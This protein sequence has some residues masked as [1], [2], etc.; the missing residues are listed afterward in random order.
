MI[1][2]GKTTLPKYEDVEE[3][4]K[5]IFDTGMVSDHKYVKE[6]EEK[7]AELIGVK[8][9]VAGPSNTSAMIGCMSLVDK[10]EVIM[11]SFTIA[12]TYYAL[13]WNNLDPVL[14][15]CDEYCNIDVDEVKKNINEKTKAVLAVYM[16]G[17]ISK[18][19]EL[20]EICE[21]K[22]VDL[23][24]DAAQGFGGKWKGKYFGNFGKG[25]IFSF[26]PSKTM[27]IGE[28]AIVTTNDDKFAE[29]LRVVFKNG[30][31]VPGNMDSVRIGLNGRLP[32]MCAVIGI[33]ALKKINYY[34]ER[35]NK[36]A[37][38][39]KK[40]LKGIEGVKFLGAPENCLSTFKDLIITVDEGRDELKEELLKRDIHTRKYFYPPIHW[41]SSCKDEFKDLK[42]PKT[43]EMSLKVLSLPI[44]SHMPF[45]DVEEVCKNIREIKGEN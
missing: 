40:N 32:E 13:K 35:R 21:E 41:M 29:D 9:A 12:N 10:G 45:E 33:E 11:P 26:D 8:H 2:I 6:F 43:E 39:Y 18:M 42:L 30:M 23:F 14:V 38:L 25:E 44:Y 31:Q 19:D 1:P 28:G 5:E 37:E 7:A 4:F 17:S 34:I 36:L 24:I 22:N 3:R 27:G 20:V 15:D 16:F